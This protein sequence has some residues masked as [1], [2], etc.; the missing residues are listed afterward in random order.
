MEAPPQPTATCKHACSCIIQHN[1]SINVKLPQYINIRK[2]YHKITQDFISVK[3]PNF[4][5]N[6]FR[7][8]SGV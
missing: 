7:C 6:V 3:R 1:K 5:D 4:A 8:G 2:P